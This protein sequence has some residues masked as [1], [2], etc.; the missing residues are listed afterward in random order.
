V[1]ASI[2]NRHDVQIPVETVVICDTSS[3]DPGA[4]SPGDPDKYTF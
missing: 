4:Q 2:G 1:P 3:I